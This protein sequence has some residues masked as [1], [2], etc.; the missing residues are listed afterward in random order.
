VT[1]AVIAGGG[2]AGHVLPGIAIARA[3]VARGHSRSDIQFVG[4]ARGIE[5]RLVPEAGFDVALLPGRGIQRRLTAANLAAAWGL[6]RAFAKAFALVWRTRPRVVVALGGYASVPCGLAAAMLRVPIVVM[7]Q[8]AVPGLANRLVARFALASAVSFPGTALPRAEVT[9]NPVRDEVLRVDRDRDRVAARSE[10]G[11]SPDRDFVVA[12]G[13]SLGA[14]RINTAV[15]DVVDAW[16]GRG[17]VAIRHVIGD[18]DWELF[19][20]R[21]PPAGRAL[22]Y[23]P[24]RYEDRMHLA[25]AAADV[26]VTR[27]GATTVAELAALGVPAIVVPLP[28]APGDHQTANGRVLADAGAAVLVPDAELDGPRLAAEL[29]RLLAEPATIDRMSAAARS[30]GRRDAAQRVADLVERHA[31]AD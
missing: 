6:L 22:V 16:A 29:G 30:V 11:V 9:G 17:D 27:A 8:N 3:L 4:S 18:R 26:A 14:R 23:E 7:E 19:E 21:F 28:G 1:W 12:F 24:V 2:T 15:L 20:P 10:L 13:G 25:L 31:R 5:H